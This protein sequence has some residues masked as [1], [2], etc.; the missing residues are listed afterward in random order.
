MTTLQQISDKL[1]NQIPSEFSG[2][3][4]SID[5]GNYEFD[6]VKQF[7][8]EG[9][10]YLY[11][12]KDPNV[13]LMFNEDRMAVILYIKNG[14]EVKATSWRLGQKHNRTFDL[15]DLDSGIFK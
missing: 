2:D 1:N 15:D 14:D 8:N 6:N 13:R 10:L 5:I 9:F 3:M 7:D 4:M 11:T 12:G